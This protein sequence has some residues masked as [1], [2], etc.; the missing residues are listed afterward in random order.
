MPNLIQY[1]LR[2]MEDGL[3][4]YLGTVGGTRLRCSSICYVT[5]R[6]HG[7]T[8]TEGNVCGLYDYYP[9]PDHSVLVKEYYQLYCT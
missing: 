2:K 7:F 4:G 9:L 3:M 5:P 1:E 8:H 6:C